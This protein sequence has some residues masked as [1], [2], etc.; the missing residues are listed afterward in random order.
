M[1][2]QLLAE[3]D[4]YLAGQRTL[5][6]VESWLVSRL[7]AISRSDDALA[8]EI[9]NQVD[10]DLIEFGEGI[11]SEDVL[12]ERWHDHV[13]RGRTVI[14]S[15]TIDAHVSTGTTPASTGRTYFVTASGAILGR[16]EGAVSANTESAWEERSQF[17]HS[18]KYVN[19]DLVVTEVA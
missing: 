17:G 11:L 9:A 3:I 4:G 14:T 10:A 16:A 18:N 15:A 5:R 19:R 8:M 7:Q 1:L 2:S 13:R 12:W 6:D